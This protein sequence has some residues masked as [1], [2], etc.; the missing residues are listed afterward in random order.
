MDFTQRLSRWIG[1]A[2]LAG[3][4]LLLVSALFAG[5][6][7]DN[8]TWQGIFGQYG[9]YFFVPINLTLAWLI[10][11]SR[12]KLG[13]ICAI[14]GVVGAATIVSAFGQYFVIGMLGN[15]LAFDARNMLNDIAFNPTPEQLIGGLVGL[16]VPISLI[17]SGVG[18]WLSRETPRYTAILLVT[19][20]AAFFVGQGVGAVAE[21][22]SPAL[23]L[24]GLAPVGWQILTGGS[25]L[26]SASSMARSQ[27]SP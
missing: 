1:I 27:R 6:V 8:V 13:T 21:V 7:A 26:Q 15:R 5:L 24:L 4:F 20:G 23:L 19:G 22:V 2:F 17:L 14:V 16:L 18:L 12:P 11:R 3:P 10:A 25:V 9:G